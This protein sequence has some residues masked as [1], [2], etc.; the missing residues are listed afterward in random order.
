M[1]A[2]D[3]RAVLIEGQAVRAGLFAG[4]LRLAGV[5]ARLEELFE[6]AGSGPFPDHVPRDVGEQNPL[7]RLVP[8][9]AFRPHELVF[10]Q[11]FDD[12]ALG[13]EG[14]ERLVG[15]FDGAES[16]D[17]TGGAFFGVGGRAGRGGEGGPDA[18]DH[19]E[20]GEA[21]HAR[22][23]PRGMSGRIRECYRNATAPQHK[24]K[25]DPTSGPAYN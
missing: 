5:P 1:L 13:D 12:F 4:E 7:V 9:G 15:A 25:G 11:N 20:V 6:A 10:G 3:E 19:E 18:D 24:E 2:E 22:V 21:D 14:V 23:T 16:D 17:L 8:D